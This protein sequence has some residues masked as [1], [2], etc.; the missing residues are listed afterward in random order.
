MNQL[1]FDNL[2]QKSRN[3]A[4]AIL[5]GG[6]LQGNTD[7]YLKAQPQLA[8]QESVPPPP[9]AIFR[10]EGATIELDNRMNM[11]L[12]P[13]V[14]RNPELEALNSY[15][16]QRRVDTF[17]RGQSNQIVGELIQKQ[18]ELKAS[19]AI[20]DEMDRRAGIRRQVLDMTGL[21]PAQID[22]QLVAESFAGINPRTM[23]M[24]ERQVED[25]VARFYSIQ[26]IPVP[27]MNPT[28]NPVPATI[29]TEVAAELAGDISPKPE[30]GEDDEMPGLIPDEEGRP[31]ST[32][33]GDPAPA[34]ARIAVDPDLRELP[35]SIEAVATLPKRTL[36]S[37]IFNLQ[38]QS[39]LTTNMRTGAVKSA[40]TLAGL[41]I[42][43]LRSVV[44]D[45]IIRRGSAGG[46]GGG[47]VGNP[48][49]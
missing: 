21:T 3:Q 40:S 45:E 28:T 29:P 46:G 19:Q 2:L 27:V 49:L 30:D 34:S 5:F 43:M 39:E 25:A 36:I 7:T 1:T 11:L 26:N 37:L 10:E 35:Q 12:K 17:A 47:G 18:A 31:A 33:A 42:G 22:Q 38:I 44:E 15:F 32:L 14:P 16:N 41:D 6:D 13:Q 20:R 24:R 9:K 23:D 8:S 4:S 48:A